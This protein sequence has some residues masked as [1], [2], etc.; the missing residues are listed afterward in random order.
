MVGAVVVADGRVVGEGWHEGPGTPHA[1][2]YGAAPAGD[3][4]RG[5]TLYVTLEPC[6]HTGR[7]G[8]APPWSPT[9]AS[10]AWWPPS[11]TPNPGRRPRLLAPSLPRRRG[12]TGCWPRRPRADQ[13][14]RD[15][16]STG[17]PFV[18]LKLAASLDGRIAAQDGSSTWITGEEARATPT[19]CGPGP[20][21]SWW[22]RGPRSPIG[23]GLTVRLD[24][25]RGPAAAARRGGCIGADPTRR[26]AVRRLGVHAHPDVSPFHEGA[27][28]EPGRSR[29]RGRGERPP[30]DRARP[31]P[32]R[33]GSR[34]PP[35]PRSLDRGWSTLA[36]SA[37]RDGVVDRLVLYLAPKLVG[38]DAAP[39]SSGARGSKRWRMRRPVEVRS[40]ERLGSDIKVVADVHR[41]R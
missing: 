29:S 14:I 9:P 10:R 24:G 19:A 2:I 22:G 41:D 1:E 11:R 21:P 36:W 23:P 17:L 35:D 5:A 20:A 27:S 15:A 37:V 32:G 26:S 8:P 38:G 31:G 13:R 4:A 39:A 12:R 18:T 33:S 25:Y 28:V 34:A 6:A 30:G 3:R 7:T 16:P 40:I